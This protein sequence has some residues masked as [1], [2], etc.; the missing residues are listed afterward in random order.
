VNCKTKGIVIGHTKHTDSMLILHAF[1][2]ELGWISFFHRVGGKDKSRALF[3]AMTVLDLDFEF[4]ENKDLQQGIK[5]SLNTAFPNIYNDVTRMAVA[6]FMAEVLRKSL[7]KHYVNQQLFHSCVET[8]DAL[9]RNKDFSILPISFMLELVKA[10]GFEIILPEIAG[11]YRFDPEEGCFT[12]AQSKTLAQLDTAS[13]QSLIEL[14]ESP[15]TAN[16]QKSVPAS[17]RKSILRVLLVFLKSHLGIQQ[18]IKSHE[19]LEVVLHT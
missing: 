5:L 12:T 17:H 18:E 2:E 1:T 3:Q 11:Q 10:M 9:N 16:Y 7:H 14:I 4:K 6:M 13:S 8:L 15:D 19:V